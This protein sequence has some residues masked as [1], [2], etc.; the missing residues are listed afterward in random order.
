MGVLRDKISFE[1]KNN[2]LKFYETSTMELFNLYKNPDQSLITTQNPSNL[3]SGNFYFL[4]YKDD[5]NWMQYSPIFFIDFK[6]VKNYT[7]GYAINMNFIPFEIRVSFFDNL[8]KDLEDDTLGLSGINF[9]SMYK[10][11]LKIGYEY[12]IVE[13]NL[14]SIVGAY[15][16]N[17]RILHKFLYS[18]HPSMGV[19]DPDNLYKLWL[20]KLETKEKRHQE[21]IKQLTSDL[22]EAVDYIDGKYDELSSHIKRFQKNIKKYLIY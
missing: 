5:S 15:S 10:Q 14:E 21:V 11:L 3:H 12:S 8:I 18:S 13:Y 2:L 4:F 20:K 6:V 19:Y 16:I 1:S 22:F 9:E 17:N 7:I